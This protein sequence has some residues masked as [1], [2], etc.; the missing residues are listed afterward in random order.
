MI[1]YHVVQLPVIDDVA[2]G[3]RFFIGGCE[4]T[5]HT[6]CTSQIFPFIKKDRINGLCFFGFFRSD[7]IQ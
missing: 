6:G 5:H 2:N 1:L 4:V 3:Y 7:L